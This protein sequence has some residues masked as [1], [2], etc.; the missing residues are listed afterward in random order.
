MGRTCDTY[1]RYEKYVQFHFR[2]P[3]GYQLLVDVRM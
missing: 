1:G 2:K 3:E